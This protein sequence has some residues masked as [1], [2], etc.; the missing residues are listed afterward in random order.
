MRKAF[1][2]LPYP[3]PEDGRRSIWVVTEANRRMRIGLVLSLPVLV[4]EMGGHLPGLDFTEAIPRGV[5]NW[6]Q[7]ALATPVTLWCGLPFFQRGWASLAT[8]NLN[9]F[10]LIAMG[11]A[12]LNVELP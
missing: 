10:T 7:L 4:L 2:S 1:L 8:R 12:E 11:R 3:S 6:I 9:M 5:S